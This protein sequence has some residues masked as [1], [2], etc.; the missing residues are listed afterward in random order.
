M[1]SFPGNET[2][3]AVYIRTAAGG[4]GESKGARAPWLPLC[5]CVCPSGVGVLFF[6]ACFLFR[7]VVTFLF[8]FVPVSFWVWR[9]SVHGQGHRCRD[10]ETRLPP[11]DSIQISQ[12]R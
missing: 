4:G 9:S 11:L 1:G 12:R 5:V 10:L 2:L 8:C 6:R 7:N 3:P